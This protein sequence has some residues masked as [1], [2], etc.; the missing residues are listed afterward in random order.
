VTVSSLIAIAQWYGWHPVEQYG[1]PSGLFYSQNR[2]AEVALLVFAAALALRQWW[3]IPGIVPALVLPYERAVWI[4]AAIVLAIW[5]WQRADQFCRFVLAASAG[6]LLVG[7][8][9]TASL[10]R[11]SQFGFEGIAERLAI[12]SFVVH[13]LSVFGHGLGAFVNDGPLLA[14][15]VS[16]GSHIDYVSR[17]EHPHNEWLWLAYEGG[18]VAVALAV[19]FA[20]AVWRACD[21]GLRLVLVALFIVSCLAMPFHDPATI[22]VAIVC[23]GFGVGARRRIRLSD[24]IRGSPLRAWVEGG[25]GRG[26]ESG[27]VGDGG[28]A[29]PVPATVS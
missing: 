10:W 20:V 15:P 13:H 26:G 12:W 14:W 2:L 18:A 7:L 29:L 8:A 16:P 9:M 23:A 19:G 27:G 1:E 22:G 28:E 11:T 25:R 4:G 6:W 24:D 5:G 3:F 17:A 21:D